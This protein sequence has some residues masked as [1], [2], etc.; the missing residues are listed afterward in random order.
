MMHVVAHNGARIWGGAER[1]TTLLLAGLQARGHRVLLLCNDPLVAQRAGEM[2]IETEILPLGGDGMVPHAFRLARRL[3]ALRPDAFIIGTY[4]KL[5]LAALGA[6]MARVPRIVARVGLET[7]TP[8]SAKYRFALPR[9][10]HAVAVNARRMRPAFADLPGFGPD[11]VAVIHNGVEPPVRLQPPGAVRASLGISP[12]VP[13]VGAVARLATQKR[14][15]RLLRAVAQLPGVHCILAGDGE[16]RARLE[17]LAA[18]LGIAARVH[19]LGHRAD[20]GDVLDAI[21][22]FVV[23]SDREGLSNSM[24]EA[25]AAGVPVVST[26][27]SGADDALEPFADGTAPGEIVGFSED[28]IASALRRLIADPPRRAAMADAARRRAVERFGMDAMLAR[29]EA[30]LAGRALPEAG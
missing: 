15:D 29:W 18:E 20:T 5:F 21:D 25:L 11:R 22:V 30:L 19:C 12:D 28:E 6:R 1:A 9:W 17:A 8:R 27:V 7:D 10:V 13:T 4:K 23:S 16:E 2:G 14:L 3:R 26:P 24:L